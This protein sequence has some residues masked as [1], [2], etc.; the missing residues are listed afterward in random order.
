MFVIKTQ[1]QLSFHDQRLDFRSQAERG[2][3]VFA[4]NGTRFQKCNNESHLRKRVWC[5]RYKREIEIR[6]RANDIVA[7][8]L[9]SD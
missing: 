4:K 1:F 7:L 9:K 8:K 6:A 5:D 3:N 2:A